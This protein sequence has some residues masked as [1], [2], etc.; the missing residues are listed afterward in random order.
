MKMQTFDSVFDAISNTPDEAADL[1]K[2]A[3][4]MLDIKTIINQNHWTQ[5]QAARYGSTTQSQIR[6]LI[7]GKIY[8]FSLETLNNIHKRFIHYIDKS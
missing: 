4:L 7:H 8:L 3:E 1:K 6:D 5:A 2:R